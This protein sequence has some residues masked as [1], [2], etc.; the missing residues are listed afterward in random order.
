MNNGVYVNEETQYVQLMKYSSLRE[1][2]ISPMLTPYIEATDKYGRLLCRL[3]IYLGECEPI[4]IQDSVIRDLMAD[5]FDFLY[6][7]RH[8]IIKGQTLVAYPLARRAYESLSLLHWC[9]LDSNTA[10]KWAKGTQFK[11][12]D[13]RRA[14]GKHPMGEPEADLRK[15]YKFFCEMTHPNREMIAYRG[16]GEGNQFVFG[17][18]GKPNLIEVADYCMKHLELWHWLCPTVAWFYRDSHIQADPKFYDEYDEARQFAQQVKTWLVEQYNYV[19]DEWHNEG[20]IVKPKF[21]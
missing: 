19:L 11:N 10:E 9:V 7:S 17:S 8:F 18:V 2:E 6:E 14:L 5:I 15:L 16:L 12:E 4:S 1:K 3:C 13:I 21:I 20:G